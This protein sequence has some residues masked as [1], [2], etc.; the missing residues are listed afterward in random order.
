MGSMTENRRGFLKMIA[1][2]AMVPA[3]PGSTRRLSG[4]EEW[5][6]HFPV[7]DQKINGY[8]IAYLDTAATSQR[9]AEV[10]DALMSFYRRDNANP[11]RTLHSLA[12]RADADYEDARRTAARFINAADPLEIVFTRGTTEGINLVATAWGGANLRRGDEVLLTISEHASSMLPWQLAAKRA[13]ATIRY[14]DIDDDGAL[15]LD[16]LDAM[17]SERTKVFAFMHVSNVLGRINPAKELC[18]RAHRAGAMVMIDAAQSAPHFKIDVRDLGCDF[19][20]FS[21]HKMMGPMGSGV[22]WG[23]REMLDAMPPYQ[24]GSNMAHEVGLESAHYSDGALKFGAGTPNVSGAVGLAAAMRFI[25]ALGQEKLFAHEQML[26]RYTLDRF[27]TVKGLRVLGPKSA[28]DRISVFSFVMNG[29]NP[30][31]IVTA[32]DQKGIAIRGGDLASLPLLERLGV[33]R[34]ARASLY[35]YS[36]TGEVDR[37][38]EGLSAF[39][40]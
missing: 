30:Q 21:G 31:D 20:A 4:V 7:L 5:R 24:A 12:R 29:A 35:L 13:G 3:L 9:P 40:K 34:A 17:L 25:L 14:L 28:D 18:A 37:L 27:R 26:T 15:R 6:S 32:L 8:P 38:I 23:R 11:G 22:L 10:I 2:L 19:V 1:P 33:T 16:Q 36:T 39:A